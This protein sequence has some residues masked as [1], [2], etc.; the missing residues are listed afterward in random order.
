[1]TPCGFQ[2]P[3]KEAL[4]EILENNA[5]QEALWGKDAFAIALRILYVLLRNGRSV[6]P[7]PPTIRDCT[8]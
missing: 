7:T 5:S 1:M 4:G 6:D 3:C 8:S 2:R